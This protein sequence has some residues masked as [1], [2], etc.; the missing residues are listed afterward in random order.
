M[1]Y[2]RVLLI[3]YNQCVLGNFVI[4]V[5]LGVGVCEGVMSSRV[6]AQPPENALSSIP[7]LSPY[8]RSVLMCEELVADDVLMT[9]GGGG[10]GGV[11]AV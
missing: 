2:E 4:N 5:W 1:Q 6:L 11:L 10:G 7:R 3:N 8:S 9:P